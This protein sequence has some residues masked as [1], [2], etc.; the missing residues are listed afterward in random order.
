M[1]YSQEKMFWE[2]IKLTNYDFKFE[3]Q[4]CVYLCDL[5]KD[6]YEFVLEGDKVVIYQ[7]N[8]GVSEKTD[9]EQLI[10]FLQCETPQM[11][12]KRYR[13]QGDGGLNPQ[14]VHIAGKW[15]NYSQ[16][17][18]HLQGSIGSVKQVRDILS[19]MKIYLKYRNKC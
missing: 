1:D 6:Q 14:K 8:K 12:K 9:T 10:Y 16:Q 13:Q 2:D 5:L 15:V 18:A 19:N 7:K 4:R 11:I 3:L 17:V